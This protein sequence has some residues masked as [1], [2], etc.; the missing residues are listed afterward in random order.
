MNKTCIGVVVVLGMTVA[1]CSSKQ[2]QF[3]SQFMGGCVGPDG[4]SQQ[5]KSCACIADKLQANHSIDDLFIL[6]EQ[7][8][9]RL[10]Q[11]AAAYAP[12]C[13]ARM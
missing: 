7:Q 5:K 2:S 1:G 13:G 12:S 8:P 9:M 10:L 3:E 11:E 4:G 6:A